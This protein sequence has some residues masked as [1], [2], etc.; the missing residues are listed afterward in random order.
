MDFFYVISTVLLSLN[1]IKIIILISGC[2]WQNRFN[3][4]ISYGQIPQYNIVN[5]EY[6]NNINCKKIIKYN[7]KYEKNNK[8]EMNNDIETFS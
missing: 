1:G 6:E 2:C 8:N 7:T 4:K 3:N 5:S